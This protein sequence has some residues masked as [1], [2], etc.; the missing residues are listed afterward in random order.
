MRIDKNTDASGT[1]FHGITVQATAR[2]ISAFMGESVFSCN[3]T[4]Y[5]WVATTDCGQIFTVY[6]WK[7]GDITED[8]VVHFHIGGFNKEATEKA[9]TDI[10]SHL[11]HIHS[12]PKSSVMS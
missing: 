8:T 7:E 4:N 1:S 12:V 3:K 2:Q 6:D 9:K 5:N 11:Y 10:L